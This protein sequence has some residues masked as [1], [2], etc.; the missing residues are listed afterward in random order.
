MTIEVPLRRWR[1]FAHDEVALV[2]DADW[3]LVA[4]YRWTLGSKGYVI[5]TDRSSGRKRTLRLHRVVLGLEVGD[6][7]QGDHIDGNPLDCRRA[8]LRVL[9]PA[10]NA[11]NRQVDRRSASGIRGVYKRKEHRH[12]LKPWVAHVRIDGHQRT[13]GYFATAEEAERCAVETRRRVMPFA[14]ERS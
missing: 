3:L 9:T 7:R 6:P 10:Q 4:P 12:R 13:L 2:D 14:V 11:Q 8:N 5:A 1:G